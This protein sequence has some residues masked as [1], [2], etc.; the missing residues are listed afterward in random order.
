MIKSNKLF[1]VGVV[2]MLGFAACG[3][4]DDSGSA[5]T[6]APADD[7]AADDAPAAGGEAVKTCLVTGL[8][9][10]DDQSF[11]ASAWQG[12]EDAIAAYALVTEQGL[13]ALYGTG[14]EARYAW[15]TLAMP[16]AAR[17][18][19]IAAGTNYRAHA[20]EASA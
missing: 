5:T 10:I 9:G 2:A 6:E 14:T 11:N 20:A 7:G 13:R 4:D 12:V 3:S 8:A 1:A 19:N 16:L 18:P 15:S 17:Y